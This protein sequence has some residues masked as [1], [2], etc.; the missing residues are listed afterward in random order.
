MSFTYNNI[1]QKPKW[2]LFMKYNHNGAIPAIANIKK[3]GNAFLDKTNRSVKAIVVDD[4][5]TSI[6]INDTA[7][8]ISL[9]PAGDTRSA[10]LTVNIPDTTYSEGSRIFYIHNNMID[11]VPSEWNININVNGNVIEENISYGEIVL[12][13]IDVDTPTNSFAITGQNVFYPM[14]II[15]E[16]DLDISEPAGDEFK[17]IEGRTFTLSKNIEGQFSLAQLFED[18]I[19]VGTSVAKD[20]SSENN[21]EII[22]YDGIKEYAVVV[23]KIKKYRNLQVI[24]NEHGETQYSIKKEVPADSDDLELLG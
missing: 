21:V 20:F 19:I 24:G 6:D 12:L 4:I 15:G 16:D 13:V 22:L 9:S 1:V 23:K 2:S 17:D 10:D 7:L 14:G 18:K 8:F 3:I 5:D 11:G